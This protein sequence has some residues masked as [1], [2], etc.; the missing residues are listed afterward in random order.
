LTVTG[1]QTCALP[2]LK[3]YFSKLPNGAASGQTET[4]DAILRC[5]AAPEKPTDDTDKSPT[6]SPFQSFYTENAAG[7]ATN[8]GGF[9]IVSSYEIGRAPGREREWSS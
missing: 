6:P 5:P 3:P 4:R 1:V 7:S 2:I 9:K 8:A